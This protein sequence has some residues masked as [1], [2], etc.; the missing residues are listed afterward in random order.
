MDFRIVND[1]IQIAAEEMFRKAE[2][3][4]LGRISNAHPF[5]F[6]RHGRVDKTILDETNQATA[7]RSRTQDCNIQLPTAANFFSSLL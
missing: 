6:Y 4:R 3:T 1:A 2:T 7:N 5:D